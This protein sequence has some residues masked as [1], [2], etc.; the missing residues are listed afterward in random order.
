MI[1][2]LDIIM[3]PSTMLC[4]G[5]LATSPLFYQAL[6]MPITFMSGLSS[7]RLAILASQLLNLGIP[8]AMTS[9]STSILTAYTLLPHKQ[10][11]ASRLPSPLS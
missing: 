11:P 7:A 3:A 10:L 2:S 1:L 4:R 8:N 6:T 5:N 9:V